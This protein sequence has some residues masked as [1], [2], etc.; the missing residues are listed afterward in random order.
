[1]SL[2][3]AN[4]VASSPIN[5]T[6]L[7]S[8][9]ETIRI[10]LN[11]GMV[12]GDRASGWMTAEHVYGPDFYLPN[13]HGT[14]TSGETYYRTRG[15]DTSLAV[16]FSHYLG[17]PAAGQYFPIPGMNV[18]LQIPENINANGGHRTRI[19]ASLCVL[20]YGGDGNGTVAAAGMNETETSGGVTYEAGNLAVIVDGAVVG[21]RNQF[22]KGSIGGARN[23]QAFYPRK[24]I[25]MFYSAALDRGVHNF[26]VGIRPRTP[27]S[28]GMTKHLIILN[29]TVDVPYWCR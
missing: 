18:T 27:S 5:A 14:L 3:I 10:Y 22:F 6:E 7:T 1:M 26:G 17:S 28:A 11:E 23:L 16:Y 21:G 2:A 24:Q 19:H 25:S 12:A 20:E 9:L 8:V 29:G 15:N 4:I 13:P